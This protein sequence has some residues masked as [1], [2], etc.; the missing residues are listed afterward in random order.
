MILTVSL[1]NQSRKPYRVMKGNLIGIL[2]QTGKL[3]RLYINTE[4]VLYLDFQ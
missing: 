2:I 1:T 4:M 3:D